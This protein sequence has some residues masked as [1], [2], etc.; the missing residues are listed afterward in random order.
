[1][2]FCNQNGIP[3][4]LMAKR[5][6]GTVLPFWLQKGIKICKFVDANNFFK[7]YGPSAFQNRSWNVSTTSGYDFMAI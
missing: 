5:T 7:K 4:V 6:A 2:H 1:M 3:Q